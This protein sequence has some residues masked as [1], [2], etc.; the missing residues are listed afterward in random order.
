[1][2][3]AAGAKPTVFLRDYRAPAWRI[4]DVALEF[5]L[6]PATPIVSARL[7]VEPDPDQ[8]GAPLSCW[9]AKDSSSS[10]F[11][12]TDASSRPARTSS[13]RTR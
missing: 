4:R 12:S 2:N 9:T 13:T 5:E 3:S 6:E 7:H 11:A 1:M 10:S 8:T